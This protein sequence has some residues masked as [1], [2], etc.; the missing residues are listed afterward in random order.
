MSDGGKGSKPRPISD[1]EQFER[2]FDAIF[3]RTDREQKNTQSDG[4]AQA[5]STG[6]KAPTSPVSD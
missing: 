1:R 2:N 6:T 5:D 4:K 3:R